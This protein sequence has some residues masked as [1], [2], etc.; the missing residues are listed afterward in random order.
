MG[1]G[2]NGG[3]DETWVYYHIEMDL[4]L[5]SVGPQSML[6]IWLDDSTATEFAIIVSDNQIRTY[7]EWNFVANYTPGESVFMEID[8]DFW[9]DWIDISLD[10]QLTHFDT[11]EFDYLR[12]VMLLG[13]CRELTDDFAVDNFRVCGGGD[14][15]QDPRIDAQPANRLACEG[16]SATF[17]V[18][19]GG[20]DPI[21]YQWYDES[22]SMPGEVYDQLIFY[23]VAGTD[24]GDYY[25]V[26][27]NV[28]GSVTSNTATL[29]VS[30]SANSP[31]ITSHPADLTVNNG[32]NAVFEVAATGTPPLSYQWRKDGANIDGALGFLYTIYN[33]G[34]SDEADYDVVVTDGC[35]STRTSDAATLTVNTTVMITSH[36]QDAEVC[37]GNPHTFSVTATGSPPL[38]YQWHDTSGPIGTNSSTY[39]IPSVSMADINSYWVVVS[40]AFGS[41]TSNHA[42]LTVWLNTITV[43]DPVYNITTI[44]SAIDLICDTGGEIILS[45]GTYTGWGNRNVDFKGKNVHLHS[46]SYDPEACIVDCQNYGRGFIL[47]SGENSNAEIQGIT[48]T[49]AQAPWPEN[50]GGIYCLASSPTIHDCIISYCAA[51]NGGGLAGHFFNGTFYDCTF[52]G[53]TAESKGGA[54]Y[55]AESSEVTPS[56]DRCTF[57]AND[58]PT[59]GGICLDNSYIWQWMQNCIISDGTQGGAVRCVNGGVIFI[60]CSDVWN[61]T[62]GDWT[63]CLLSF[64]PPQYNNIWMD[65]VYCS[66]AL[67][68]FTLAS[69][70]PCTAANQPTCGRM[71]AWPEGCGSQDDDDSFDYGVEW[72]DNYKGTEDDRGDAGETEAGSM[73]SGLNAQGWSKGFNNGDTN[74][75]ESHWT[76]HNNDYVDDVDLV[77]FSGHGTSSFD[78]HYQKTMHGPSFRESTLLPGEAVGI[79]GNDDA[80]WFAFSCCELLCKGGGYWSKTLDGGHLVLGYKTNC[81]RAY[82]RMAEWLKHMLSNGPADPAKR[83]AWS[84]FKTCDITQP[85]NYQARI[86]GETY[87][88][89]WDYLWGQGGGVQPDPANDNYYTRWDHLKGDTT[90]TVS[91]M[92]RS[93]R[94]RTDM[95]Y[96]DVTP[97]TIDTAD[98]EELGALLGI[99]GDVEHYGDGNFY[100]AG[101]GKY[102]VMSE[103]AGIDYGYP[104]L[105]WV[106]WEQAPYLPSLG[107]AEAYADG[108][109]GDN[110]LLPGDALQ[111]PTVF[112]SDHQLEIDKTTEMV[113]DSFATDIAVRHKRQ[114]N[115]YPVVGPGSSCLTYVSEGGTIGGHMQVWRSLG[116]S[117][118]I[119]IMDSAEVMDLFEQ[120]GHKVALGGLPYHTAYDITEMD[121]AYYEEG[122]GVDQEHIFPVYTLI[123]DFHVDSVQFEHPDIVFIPAAEMFLPLVSEI[124]NPLN[125]AFFVAGESVAFLGGGLYGTAPYTYGWESDQDGDMGSDSSFTTSS[126]S[127]GEHAVT[128]TV[129]DSGGEHAAAHVELLITTD[130]DFGD[131]PDPGYPTLLASGGPRHLND[132][133]TYLGSLIDSEP[134]GQPNA[135]ATGD[136]LNGDA[137]EDGVTMTMPMVPG[138]TA[139]VEVTAST[140]GFLSAWID[141]NGDQDWADADERIFNDRPLSAGINYL[142]FDVPPDADAE[143]T[144]ARFR[145]NSSGGSL[146]YGGPASDGEVEDYLVTMEVGCAPCPGGSSEES[147]PCGQRL[148]NGCNLDPPAFEYVSC[149]D[150]F[151]AESFADT[152]WRDSDWFEISVTEPTRLT[153]TLVAE[154]P[155]R[156]GL[157]EPLIP[158][159]AHCDSMTGYVTPELL[160]DLCEEG[161]LELDLT[162]AGTYWLAMAPQVFEGYPCSE[163]PHRIIFSIDCLGLSPALSISYSE[164][165]VTLDWDP[166]PGADRYLVYSASEAWATFPGGWTLETAP[167]GITETTWSE[168]VVDELK[169]YRIVALSESLLRDTQRERRDSLPYRD[170]MLPKLREFERPGRIE[171]GWK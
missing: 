44:Q 51:E 118:S 154:L 56:P 102:L 12:G 151:C 84:W 40:N 147:E 93:H 78:W 62:G 37:V 170:T 39:T 47:Q 129:T 115:G 106:P 157:I 131:A 25:V 32:D 49:R 120:H 9:S 148:N 10:G 104:A 21:S 97:T 53:N 61:N 41:A 95:P 75:D 142:S 149:G 34:L 43:P 139:G 30:T 99:G 77:F 42:L 161:V 71:G 171:S 73:E 65:P 128:L 166:V 155:M 117:H 136:D 15:L 50:G 124:L 132:N 26:V 14:C 57:Y 138:E 19:A 160:V 121:L 146:G 137:D 13:D 48:I 68:D 64:A 27:S 101:S 150:T 45:D 108:F 55:L 100:M 164:G 69:N 79:W 143:E 125:D 58:A 134:E 82:D 8:L 85:D 28:L 98:V 91:E 35:N 153:W 159:V 11:L 162:A 72:V 126:L 113:L 1:E 6:Q 111:G 76:D 86:V 96:Y 112:H 135:T 88:M 152:S 23:P 107:E 52:I 103:T 167:E 7:P 29:T 123:V 165:E 24:A 17:S 31:L 158:G 20:T 2:S 33:C 38:N 127:T 140:T 163:G 4:L 119:S 145:F 74:A 46:Q 144:F 105:Q 3:F 18:T 156:F 63:D 66:P 130:V 141:F 89:S 109:L 5:D 90:Y 114:I 36:P 16:D 94:F 133:Q 122:F 67:E 22:G 59:G 83:V 169:F 70:S 110:G 54:V 92:A 168:S 81:S 116:S 87:Q 60:R 80:E